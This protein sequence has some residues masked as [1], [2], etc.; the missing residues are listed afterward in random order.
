MR[1]LR[2]ELSKL[3]SLPFTWIAVA[4]GLIMPIGITAITRATGDPR[5]DSS[6]SEFGLGVA[7]VIVLG[8]VIISSE[9]TT[10][11]EESASS[12]QITTTLTVTGSR[13]KAMIAKALALIIATVALWIP[14]MAGVQT[15]M[16]FS[17]DPRAFAFDAQTLGQV[18]GTLVYWV[19]T[20][21]LAFALTMIVRNG[22]IPMAVLVA[23][24]SAVAVTY[25]LARGLAPANY[26]PDLAGLR[27]F[28]TID[29]N[30]EIA[31]LAG[32]VIMA[33]WVAG[34][35]VVAGI[36]FTRRDA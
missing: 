26:L 27:M 20:A 36:V 4:T 35:L 15:V 22:I 23:N 14:G 11:G 13:L 28:T 29:T 32:G 31:P 25:L 33:A 5:A 3:L 2:S 8:V 6:F 17:G 34:L 9:Y 16:M 21:L 1:A 19:L 30:V 24:S 7:G 12:R 18:L 10:E